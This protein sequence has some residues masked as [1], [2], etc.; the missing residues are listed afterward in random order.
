MHSHH[1][2]MFTLLHAH[3]LCCCA[4]LQYK[5]VQGHSKKMV[6]EFYPAKPMEVLEGGTR[7]PLYPAGKK[8]NQKN[9]L[10]H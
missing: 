5:L 8:A 6:L 1:C 9:G 3:Y 2:N 10:M 4:R 7:R